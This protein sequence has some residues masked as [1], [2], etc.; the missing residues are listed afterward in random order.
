MALIL[1]IDTSTEIAGICLSRAGRSLIYREHADQKD[2]AAWIH[3][4]IRN[5]MGEAGHLMAD[6]EAIAVTAGPGS[7]TGLRVSMSTAKG[8][9]YALKIPLITENSLR[10][11]AFCVQPEAISLGVSLICPMID[12]RRMEVFTAL[13]SKDLDQILAPQA[14]VL[15]KDSLAEYLSHHPI[16]FTGDGSKK[17]KE[18]AGTEKTL[19]LEAKNL[20]SCLAKMAYT[21][22]QAGE[23]TDI[24][25]SEPV[26]IKEFHTHTKK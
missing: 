24:I 20:A 1:N 26:Y 15:E 9:C 3:T 22:F 5:I 18:L 6:L 11:L 14:M 19:F 13:Y 17:W 16:A 7:Y 2:H 25:Y 23:F 21:K 4:E 12:A 10:L 8:F